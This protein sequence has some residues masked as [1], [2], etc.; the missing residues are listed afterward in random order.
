MSL[1]LALMATASTTP[2]RLWGDFWTTRGD[3][4]DVPVVAVRREE[5]IEGRLSSCVLRVDGR[6]M[7]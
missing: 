6:A 4:V 7:T 2:S 3:A 5:A 1:H